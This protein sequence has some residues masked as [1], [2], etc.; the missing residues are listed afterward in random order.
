MAKKKIMT[1]DDLYSFCLSNNFSKFSSDDFGGELVVRMPATFE[2]EEKEENRFTEG[3]TPFISKAF[4]DH[5]NLNQS[6]IPEE[7]FKDNVP[8]SHL[9]PIL[10]NIITHE[11]TGE[12]DFH[13]HDFYVEYDE[14]GN[15]HIV[16]EEQPVGVIDGSMTTIEYDEDA[17]VNRAILHGYLYDGYCQDAIDIINR[18]GEVSCSVE[19]SVRD[20]SFN[21]KDKVLTLQDFYV[22]ALTLLGEDIAPGMAG[23]NLKIE[24]FAV[25]NSVTFDRD[26]EIAKLLHELSDKLD[27]L[28]GYTKDKSAGKEDKSLEINEFEET[29]ADVVVTEAEAE[30]ETEVVETEQEVTEEFENEETETT[31]EEATPAVEEEFSKEEIF[32]KLF[33]LSFEDIRYALNALCSMYRNNEEWCYVCAVYE[34]HFIMEDWD[35][36]KFYKQSYEKDG[37]NVSLVGERAEMFQMLLTESEKTVIDEMRTNYA[38]FEE[39]SAKLAKYEAEPEKMEILN[40]ADYA[41]IAETENFKAFK[42]QDAHFDMSVEEVK[43]RADEM[44][45][46]YAKS[47]ALSFAVNEEKKPVG[48]KQLP[49]QN[50]KSTKKSRYGGMFNKD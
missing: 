20:M 4:H 17:K 23:S 41:Q 24:D 1:I 15:E 19:L 7:S 43:A 10:A 35:N 47:G 3:M 29:A 42:E 14:D 44:L 5:V 46:A 16:Y 26:D 37:D 25:K 12:K 13:S 6:E 39:V 9:R 30:V 31:E 11:D 8:S 38:K 45:L 40:S 48:M 28:S 33:E 21:A 32:N 22:S 50:M 2:K 34:D 27:S 18:R 36:N 49:V